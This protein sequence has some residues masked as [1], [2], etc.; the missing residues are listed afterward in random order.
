[1]CYIKHWLWIISINL[2]LTIDWS[3]KHSSVHYQKVETFNPFQD[4]I[5]PATPQ[6]GVTIHLRGNKLLVET[7][8]DC[9]WY[10]TFLLTILKLV[11]QKSCR[12][13]FL[14]DFVKNITY[15]TCLVDMC[16]GFIWLHNAYS[17][18]IYIYYDLVSHKYNSLIHSWIQFKGQ[19]AYACMPQLSCIFI[20]IVC[21]SGQDH[22]CFVM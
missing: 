6:Y 22:F 20:Y 13:F 10:F 14:Q 1:M 16:N 15:N 5:E 3:S 17:F 18:I 8:L 11:L 9:Y 7:M 19:M 12:S 4:F 2:L 21:V